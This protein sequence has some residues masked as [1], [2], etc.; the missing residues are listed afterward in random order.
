MNVAKLSPSSWLFN[1][2]FAIMFLLL[3]NT[4]IV[5]AGLLR[6]LKPTCDNL[7][8]AN[9]CL[10][11][12]C[13]NPDYCIIC[14]TYEEGV[15]TG[16]C[17]AAGEVCPRGSYKCENGST[18]TTT[19]TTAPSSGID[20]D[21]TKPG[22]ECMSGNCND[23]CSK[24]G[25][26]EKGVKTCAEVLVDPIETTSTSCLIDSDCSKDGLICLYTSDD[27]CGS[28]VCGQPLIDA[29]PSSFDPVW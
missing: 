8:C 18:T 26:N 6:K 12:P 28:G 23:C 27:P 5:D 16:S 2:S 3:I 29:C 7:R 11:N 19:T 1:A 15:C 17:K 10:D 22:L 24:V 25:T 14:D 9:P 20:G 4:S 13:G 21:C